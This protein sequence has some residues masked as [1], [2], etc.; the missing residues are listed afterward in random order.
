[1]AQWYQSERRQSRNIG[2]GNMKK[3]KVRYREVGS[4]RIG[5]TTYSG[6]LSKEEVVEFFELNKGDVEWYEVEEVK[7]EE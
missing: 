3:Y 1:M 7:N 4:D 6:P 2:L 5:E